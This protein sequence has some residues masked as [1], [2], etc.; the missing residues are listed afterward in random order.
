MK[1]GGKQSLRKGS[2]AHSLSHQS[3]FYQVLAYIY[4]PNDGDRSR[5]ISA[6]TGAA[7]HA[8]FLIFVSGKNQPLALPDLNVSGR[9]NF[10]LTEEAIHTTNLNLCFFCLCF[11]LQLVL[12][13]QREKE[14][15]KSLDDDAP[16][17]S[18]RAASVL[19]TVTS[20]SNL[21]GRGA[22]Q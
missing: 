18:T 16:R 9:A 6:T 11:P 13:L 7:L 10:S 15:I 8:I 22:D 17:K 20:S 3:Q 21:G 5:T 14:E 19:F 4:L 2:Q 1:K 12:G